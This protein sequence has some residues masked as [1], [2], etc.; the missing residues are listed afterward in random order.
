MNT[1]QLTRS[2]WPRWRFAAATAAL[3]IVAGALAEPRS[4]ASNSGAAFALTVTPAG[5]NVAAGSST[6]YT[7]TVSSEHGLAGHDPR[8][9]HKRN[10][11]RG[12][13]PH[14]S[15]V[16][17]RNL[18]LTSFSERNSIPRARLRRPGH[19]RRIQLRLDAL[20][21][22]HAHGPVIRWLSPAM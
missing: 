18:G 8:R 2:L 22:L 6:R 10:S 17:V 1:R 16:A 11:Q 9:D 14:V 21:D 7:L 19:H 3:F 4:Y 5:A 13:Q 15:L 12:Q 20:D